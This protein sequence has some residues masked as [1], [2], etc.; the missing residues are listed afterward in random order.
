MAISTLWIRI[1]ILHFPR[2][3]R[4][5]FRGRAAWSDS[6]ALP[7]GWPLP[8]LAY[9]LQ[10]KCSVSETKGSVVGLRK[11]PAFPCGLTSCD[12]RPI[13]PVGGR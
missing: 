6:G 9:R 12:G 3:R 5:W 2:I 13:Q 4:G 1:L 11:Q 10:G 7:I 8:V